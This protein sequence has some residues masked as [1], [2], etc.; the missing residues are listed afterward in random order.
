M[1]Q[2]FGSLL[3]NLEVQY[4]LIIIDTPP[5]LAVTDASIVAQYAATSFMVIRSGKHYL[6]EIQIAFKR[7]EQNGIQIKGIIFNGIEHKKGRLGDNY[8][9]K[10][11]GYQYEYNNK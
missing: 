7:F 8:G 10:Y 6:R 5:I 3:R 4:D 2:A 11:Y 1:S 9:Y